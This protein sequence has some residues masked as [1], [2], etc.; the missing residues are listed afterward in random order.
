MGPNDKIMLMGDF[1]ISSR[2]FNSYMM[3]QLKSYTEE[4]PGYNVF[5]EDGF[6]CLYEA[7]IMK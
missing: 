4:D 2:K 1:N 7:E 5:F 6:D 3:N